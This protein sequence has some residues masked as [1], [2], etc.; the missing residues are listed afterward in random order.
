MRRATGDGSRVV[1]GAGIE[2]EVL[3]EGE[4]CFFA[5]TKLQ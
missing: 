4:A 3:K 5:S 2:R 1:K